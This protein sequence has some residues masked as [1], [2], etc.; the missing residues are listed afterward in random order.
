M[1]ALTRPALLAAAVA[2]TLALAACSKKTTSEDVPQPDSG[3]P[4]APSTEEPAAPKTSR[5]AQSAPTSSDAVPPPVGSGQPAKNALEGVLTPEEISRYE[6]WFKKYNLTF[7]AGTLDLDSDGDGYTN[8]QEFEAGTNPRDANSVPGVMD[9]VS[10]KVVNKVEVPLILEDVNEKGTTATIKHT[11]DGSVEK[12]G[13]G[14]QP[15]GT[16]YKVSRVR[17]EKKADKHGEMVDVSNVTL[18]NTST[19]ET[20]MLVRELPA[21]SSETHAILVG[22][23]VEQ[24]VHVGD[25]VTLPGQGNK[26]FTVLDLRP[27]QVLV[28][29]NETKKPITIPKR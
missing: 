2:A 26:R 11:A 18:E 17:Y 28:E 14:A 9:G 15:K 3:S 5:T 22:N 21:L 29:D 20:V 10:V 4:A 25:V 7:D 13:E 8:R 12:I 23:G 27:D 24:K 16:P 19:K 1:K 6:A